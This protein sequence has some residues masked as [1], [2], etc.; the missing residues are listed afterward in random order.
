MTL[1]DNCLTNVK[2]RKYFLC[3]T[4]ILAVVVN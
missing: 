2:K 1:D 4:E 3:G